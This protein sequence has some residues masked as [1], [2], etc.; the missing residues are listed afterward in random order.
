M[1]DADIEAVLFDLDGTL[2]D[3]APDLARALNLTLIEHARPVLPI[4]LIRPAVSLGSEAMVQLAFNVDKD[5]DDFEAVR[6]QFL[7]RYSKSIAQHTRLFPDMDKVLS[8]LE[9]AGIVWGVVTN[10]FSWLS[11]PLMDSLRL[12]KRA[13]CV[14]SGDT[15]ARCKPHPDPMYHACK[16]IGCDPGNTVYIGDAKHDIDAGNAAGM[17]TMIALYGYIAGE[18]APEHWG[19][20]CMVKSSLEILERVRALGGRNL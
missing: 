3:T 11:Q 12:L 18:D 14:V 20:G 4:D 1:A 2:A 13:A 8:A 16:L 19:A 17:H 5:H 15:V 10:K 7:D 9:Q 6:Q